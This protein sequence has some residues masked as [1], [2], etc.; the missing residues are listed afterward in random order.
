MNITILKKSKSLKLKKDDQMVMAISVKQNF[1]PSQVAVQRNGNMSIMENLMASNSNQSAEVS[2]QNVHFIEN[3]SFS[4]ETC[5]DTDLVIIKDGLPSVTDGQIRVIDDNRHQFLMHQLA[6]VTNLIM[7]SP[8]GHHIQVPTSAPQG[9]MHIMQVGFVDESHVN[10]AN[11]LCP[12]G[13]TIANTDC[14]QG[15][16]ML[17]YN[18]YFQ[19]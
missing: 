2:H 5:S 12:S 8:D 19:A 18:K 11:H 1:E 6:P 9:E 13:Y 4:E 14:N 16:N 15:N 7:E 17:A 3:M 10:N